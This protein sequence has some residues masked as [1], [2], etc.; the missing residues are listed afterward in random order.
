MARKFPT[1][2]LFVRCREGISHHPDESVRVEDVAIALEVL[3][4]VI[5][6]LAS[7]NGRQ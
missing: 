3:V 4:R 6:K 5:Y 7:E 2:M 1:A